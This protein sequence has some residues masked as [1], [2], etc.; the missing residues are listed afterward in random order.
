MASQILHL[1]LSQLQR[2]GFSAKRK[3]R[4]IPSK[5]IAIEQ[6]IISTSMDRR[7]FIGLA[8]AAGM[9]FAARGVLAGCSSQPR[10]ANARPALAQTVEDWD[11]YNTIYLGFPV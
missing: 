3:H 6:P 7:R 5:G 1:T 9:T 8:A 10:N 4:L 11:S 2:L